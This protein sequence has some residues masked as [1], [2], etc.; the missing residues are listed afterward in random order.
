MA[1]LIGPA[2]S[3]AVTSRRPDALCLDVVEAIVDPDLPVLERAG[4]R[5]LRIHGAGLSNDDFLSQGL[6][7]SKTVSGVNSTSDATVTASPQTTRCGDLPQHISV[8][9]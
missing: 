3:L 7:L 9:N 2:R 1:L 5:E 6:E 8:L 4:Y